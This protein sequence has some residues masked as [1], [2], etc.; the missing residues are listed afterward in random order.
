MKKYIKHYENFVFIIWTFLCLLM[1]MNHRVWQGSGLA[2]SM[3]DDILATNHILFLGFIYF[4][5]VIYFFEQMTN[6]KMELQ[7]IV[8]AKR[9]EFIWI[10]KLKTVMIHAVC[11]ST[12]L[13]AGML[14]VSRLANSQWVNWNQKNSI[15]YKET[16][17]VLDISFFKVFIIV[18][19]T[20]LL[21]TVIVLLFCEIGELIWHNKFFAVI[22][23]LTISVI[24]YFWREGKIFFRLFSVSYKSW[25][26]LS[27]IYHSFLLGI[28]IIV[29]AIC[30]GIF[31][32][33]KAD[34]YN[35]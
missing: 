17:T 32:I 26:N 29:L 11:M 9:R 12:V 3:A 14:L 21:K 23:L 30:I 4:I 18:W 19:F 5:A 16:G 34:F 25:I 24:E 22:P 27:I 35:E 7:A 15:M 2:F 28:L 10:R 8:R 20:I 13:L 1:A 33:R 31:L 6:K